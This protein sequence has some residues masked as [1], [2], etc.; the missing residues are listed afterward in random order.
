MNISPDI[1]VKPIDQAI[2]DQSAKTFKKSKRI[3]EALHFLRENPKEFQIRV[4]EFDQ[5]VRRMNELL[6]EDNLDQDKYKH[7]ISLKSQLHSSEI[8]QLFDL[9]IKI[10]N[11][12]EKGKQLLEQINHTFSEVKTW[13]W[14]EGIEDNK[15]LASGALIEGFGNLLERQ[16]E[17][18]GIQR[19]FVLGFEEVGIFEYKASRIIEDV[20]PWL[21]EEIIDFPPKAQQAIRE[22]K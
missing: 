14:L 7:L 11:P 20:T 18:K 9:N 8:P 4:D 6:N 12:K 16:L 13:D 3:K 2:L 21:K 1:R 15:Q 17:T 19:N 22:M 10:H 5:I